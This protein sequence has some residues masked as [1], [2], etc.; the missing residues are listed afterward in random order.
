MTM[1]E[2]VYNT[3]IWTTLCTI[4]VQERHRGE[5]LW[6]ECEGTSWKWEETEIEPL[7]IE[8]EEEKRPN[9]SK[10]GSRGVELPRASQQAFTS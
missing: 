4:K 10:S 1:S 6:E 7:N 8:T 3:E 2:Y 9:N 5:M